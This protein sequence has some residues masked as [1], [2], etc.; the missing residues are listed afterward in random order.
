[1]YQVYYKRFLQGD[2]GALEHIIRAY[3]DGLLLY[4]HGIVGDMHLAEEL[5]EDVFVKLVVKRPKFSEKSSFKTWLYAVGR[6]VAR[7]YMRRK[8]RTAVPL[9]ERPELSDDEKDLE[10]NYIGQE[11]RILLHRAMRQLK[12]EYRQILWLVYFEDFSLS[13]AARIMGKSTHN[14]Q[15]IV[16]R[17]RKALKEKLT[18]EGYEYEKL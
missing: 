10:Q 13:Q 18:Q 12:M 16:Y 2:D 11:D 5:A 7:D 9:E 17:A 1:M 6:N 15:T 8:K 14:A 4:I 3:R